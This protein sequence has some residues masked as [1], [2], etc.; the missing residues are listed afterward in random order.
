MSDISFDRYLVDSGFITEDEHE[1][2]LQIY[3]E[4]NLTGKIAIEHNFIKQENLDDVISYQGRHGNI[5]FGEA[6]VTMHFKRN[7]NI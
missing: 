1:K 2:I 3:K 5:K 4:N 6:A 7:R